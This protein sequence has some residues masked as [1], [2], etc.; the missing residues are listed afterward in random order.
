MGPQRRKESAQQGHV[1]VTEKVS[2]SVPISCGSYDESNRNQVSRGQKLKG[3][4]R[5]SLTVMKQHEL[6]GVRLMAEVSVHGRLALLLLSPGDHD[7][8]QHTGQY[9]ASPY[10]GQ[11]KEKRKKDWLNPSMQYDLL[12]SWSK[13]PNG[14][15]I[16]EH[17]PMKKDKYVRAEPRQSF[18]QGHASSRVLP[19]TC[20]LAFCSLE[21]TG[22]L[23]V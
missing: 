6:R 22:A 11:G 12:S 17:E 2:P 16:L 10:G 14:S 15:T 20:S 23:P 21:V 7:R 19:T 9:C 5:H 8:E 18:Q 13:H 1:G 3:M 4:W